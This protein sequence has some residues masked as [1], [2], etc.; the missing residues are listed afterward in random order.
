[1]NPIEDGCMMENAIKGRKMLSFIAVLSI[2]YVLLCVLLF[3]FQRQMI[4]LPTSEVSVP[5]TAYTILDTGEVRI[6]VWTL[7]PGK[8]KALIYFGGNAENVAYNIDDFQTLFADRTVYLV[9]YRGYGG[10]SGVPH[11]QGFYHDAL[12]LY[13]HVR[14]QYA[15]ISTMG[16][17]IG[18]AVST[19]LA[20]KR[21]VDKLILITPF[22][23]AVNVA[24]K[25]YWFF[26]IDLILKE[27]LDTAGRAADITADTLIIA[28]A[29][30]RIIPHSCSLDLIKA[31]RKTR[32]EAV[33]LENTGH[34]TVHLHPDYKK[35]ITSFMR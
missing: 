17:S 31:F 25:Y 23:S 32:V 11:E 12:Y 3:V 33:T 22:D 1:M 19:Y 30:D 24:K 21:N 9:N 27:R 16:R 2:S 6:K 14:T 15:A 20:S 35:I 10:S 4:Y 28:A 7:N 26:P 18:A 5:D 8:K 34:N 29:D 13:D